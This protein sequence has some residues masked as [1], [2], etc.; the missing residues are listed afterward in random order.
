M[1]TSEQNELIIRAFGDYNVKGH[2]DGYMIW[3]VYEGKM[4]TGAGAKG[5]HSTPLRHAIDAFYR[6]N[7]DKINEILTPDNNEN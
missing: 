5:G 4:Y 7:I 1:R 6:K 2:N 3:V